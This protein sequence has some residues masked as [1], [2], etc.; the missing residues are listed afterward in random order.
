MSPQRRILRAKMAELAA[1][2]GPQHR[3][4]EIGIAG[5]DP[6]GANRE[7]IRLA[8]GGTYQTADKDAGLHPDLVLD[9]EDACAPAWRTIAPY[10]LV[11]CSQV[12]E[13]V[14]GLEV[15][16]AGLWCLTALGGTCL[17]DM[18][19]FYPPH[20]QPNRPGAPDEPDYFRLT[21]QGLK[22]LL[23]RAGFSHVE[24]WND[25][26]WLA[27]GAIATR[28]LPDGETTAVPAVGIPRTE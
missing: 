5:D 18:P 23:H 28:G 7:F 17:V 10:D 26:A 3:V 12:L 6:P 19:F 22:R 9:L 24:I 2:L 16:A 11:I 25:P 14:W 4:L 15:A 1:R 13:H 27:V 8:E 20:P 21:P